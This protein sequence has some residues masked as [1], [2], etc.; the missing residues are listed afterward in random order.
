[1]RSLSPWGGSPLAGG[2][3][4]GA[5]YTLCPG[6]TL[7]FYLERVA[8]ISRLGCGWSAMGGGVGMVGSARWRSTWHFGSARLLLGPVGLAVVWYPIF[9]RTHWGVATSASLYAG[10]PMEVTVATA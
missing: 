6:R 2:L 4:G 7:R 3:G 5:P 8:R 10:G 9:V 1:M